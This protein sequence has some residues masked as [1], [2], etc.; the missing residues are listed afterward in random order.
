M[1]YCTWY[2]IKIA[3]SSQDLSLMLMVSWIANTVSLLASNIISQRYG[4]NYTIKII[5]V[6][7]SS[8]LILYLIFS[9]FVHIKQHQNYILMLLSIIGV[10]LSSATAML[11]PLSTPIIATASNDIFSMK[12]RIKILSNTFILN[13]ILGTFL[14]GLIINVYGGGSAILVDSVLSIFGVILSLVFYIVYPKNKL[15]PDSKKRNPIDQLREGAKYVFYT[16]PERVIATVSM[17]VNMVI[18]PVIFLIFPVVILNGGHSIIDVSLAEVLVG[19]GILMSSSFL[20]RLTDRLLS[21][22]SI[23]SLSILIC[24][25]SLVLIMFSDSI[26]CLFFSALLIGVGLSLFNVTSN[27]KRALS[28]PERHLPNME[29][30]LLFLCTASIPLGFFMTKYFLKINHIE[31]ILF[32]FIGILFSAVLISSS[33]KSLKSMLNDSHEE[34]VKYYERV[35]KHIFSGDMA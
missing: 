19:V 27:T 35:Y 1:L 4:Y 31:Y 21:P 16:P 24:T 13:L 10:T 30:F 12:R 29:G 28:I 14:G 15:K 9:E 33:S 5:S 20:L 32:I 22:H 26:I 18:T 3:H 6:T 23:V 17:M 11:I 8:A 34:G 2:F 7:V 25:V